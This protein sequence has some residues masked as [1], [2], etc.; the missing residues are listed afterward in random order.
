M[1]NPPHADAGTAILPDRS[2]HR[3]LA[4]RLTLVALAI[5]TVLAGIIIYRQGDVVRMAARN[6]AQTRA[7]L[8]SASLASHPD[9]PPAELQELL[10]SALPDTGTDTG[11]FIFLRV[12]DARGRVVAQALHDHAGSL[13]AFTRAAGAPDRALRSPANQAVM[14]WKIVGD[15]PY[16]EV[17]LPLTGRDGLTALWLQGW[18][19]ISRSENR[20]AASALAVAVAGAC[21][22]V[23]LT[24]L[25]LYPVILGLIKQVGRM[26]DNLLE[27]HI[28]MLRALGSAIAERDSDTD[29]HNFRVTVYSARLA[30]AVGL[31][32][33][34]MRSL[35]KGSLLHDVGKIGV[36]DRVLL[37]P[38][39]L[40]REEFE[41]MKLH[42][43]HGLD[44]VGRSRWLADAMPVVE[45]HH[46]KMDGTGYPAGLNGETIPLLARI[47]A[48][49]DVFDALTSQRPYK[50]AF[51]YDEAMSIMREG[52]G[53]HFDPRLFDALSEFSRELFDT[54]ARDESGRAREDAAALI[55]R[56]FGT[57]LGN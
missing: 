42:V 37:K 40:D 5:S 49:A 53:T 38:G 28:E 16:L 33:D 57:T 10:A 39:K 45:C 2:I 48:I 50:K 7:A 11:H 6:D 31:D 56:Y 18:F 52:R 15:R 36:R 14:E 22:T 19:T 47:F 54:Y 34:G 44:I 32:L 41:E 13:E 30:E 26:S 29:L 8:I 24:A 17:G 3:R 27:S 46:E 12:I 1:S 55:D 9:Q 51:S 43:R 23:F 25:V 21:G 35:I 20:E 4:A